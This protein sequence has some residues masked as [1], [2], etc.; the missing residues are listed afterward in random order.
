M[1]ATIFLLF[2][3]WLDVAR[4]LLAAPGLRNFRGRGER[5]AGGEPATGLVSNGRWPGAAGRPGWVTGPA[6][7][8][9]YSF[10]WERPPPNPPLRAIGPRYAFSCQLRH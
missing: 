3:L 10:A 4:R 7:S 1:T 5:V 6:R 8:L 9:P 2:I